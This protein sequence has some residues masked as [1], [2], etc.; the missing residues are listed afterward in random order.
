MIIDEEIQN[1]NLD[2]YLEFCANI[3]QTTLIVVG[4]VRREIIRNKLKNVKNTQKRE[5]IKNSTTRLTNHQKNLSREGFKSFFEKMENTKNILNDDYSFSILSSV[6]V[7]ARFALESNTKSLFACIRCGTISG[8]SELKNVNSM[9][10]HLCDD[11]DYGV[12][13]RTSWL[14]VYATF[15]RNDAL[16][17]SL[18]LL[19]E[20]I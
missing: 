16:K 10:K 9:L 6:F 12:G 5:Q 15:V 20:L 13:E 2:K 7:R 14:Y 3:P 1:D 19:E 18:K 11:G 8:L 4:E 17:K